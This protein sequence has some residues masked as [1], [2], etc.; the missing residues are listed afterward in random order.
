LYSPPNIIDIIKTRSMRFVSH[1][2]R[3]EGIGNAYNILVRKSEAKIKFGLDGRIIL[4][5]ILKKYGGSF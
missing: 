1:I 5:G 4:I 2:T 3:L